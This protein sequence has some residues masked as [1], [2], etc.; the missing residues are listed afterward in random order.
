[1]LYMSVFFSGLQAAPFS[2]FSFP[3]F[4][5]ESQYFCRKLSLIRGASLVLDEYFP[6]TNSKD[7]DYSLKLRL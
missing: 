2:F 4:L 5:D 6:A 1:M 7:L 3:F